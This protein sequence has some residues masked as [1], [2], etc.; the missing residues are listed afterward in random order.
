[1]TMRKHTVVS[2]GMLLAAL[3][4]ACQPVTGKPTQQVQMRTID[5]AGLDSLPVEA[6]P[7]ITEEA[8]ELRA[9]EQVGADGKPIRQRPAAVDPEAEVEAPIIMP[10][11]PLI[12]MDPVDGSKVSIRVET[13]VTEYKN[14]LYYFSSAQNKTA[15]LADPELF[16]TGALSKY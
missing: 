16:A 13:P 4:G 8:T 9:T 6:P 15:F 14:R 2:G 5:D 1:M 3:A 10:F 7:M 12:A 11:A